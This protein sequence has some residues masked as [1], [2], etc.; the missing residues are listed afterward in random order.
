MSVYLVSYDL[1]NPNRNYNSLIQAIQ[2]YGVNNYYHILKSQYLVSTSQNSIEIRDFLKRHLDNND[3]ILV[4]NFDKS[5]YAAT[6]VDAP[7]LSTWLDN[8]L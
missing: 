8:H 4:N 3:E 5:D 2:S 6:V 1:H 7:K